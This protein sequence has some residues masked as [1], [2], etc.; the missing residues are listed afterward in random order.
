MFEKSENQNALVDK[1]NELSLKLLAMSEIF[2]GGKVSL[3]D[4]HKLKNL[5]SLISE[6]RNE[7]ESQSQVN[8]NL[9]HLT[10]LS[11]LAD[12]FLKGQA[13]PQDLATLSDLI[14]LVSFE[15]AKLS[16]NQGIYEY[17]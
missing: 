1:P 11:L 7:N 9:S 5:L 15:N 12:L 4:L 16:L 6:N 2:I 17:A 14:K 13:K 8:E 10:S 3:S